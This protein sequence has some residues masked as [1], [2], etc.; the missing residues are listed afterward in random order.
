MSKIQIVMKLQSSNGDKTQKL[1]LWKTQIYQNSITHIVTKVKMWQ[2]SS[3]DK[4]QI[5]TKPKLIQKSNCEEKN[6]K[7]L[8]DKTQIKTKLKNSNCDQTQKLK[9]WQNLKYDNSQLLKKKHSKGHLVR[10][11]WHLDNQWD[12]FWAAFWNPRD[13]FHQHY[14]VF[15]ARP[16]LGYGTLI[17][18]EKNL[19]LVS[20]LV[21]WWGLSLGWQGSSLGQ[22]V[23]IP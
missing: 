3:C 1:K 16:G 18:Y 6:I 8:F 4:T 22:L 12:V 5:V 17:R 20:H 9:L 11:F 19:L 10:T 23:E 2:N 21:L 14:S 15:S 13:V 7:S